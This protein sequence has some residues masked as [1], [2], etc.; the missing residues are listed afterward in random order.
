[1][2][3]VSIVEGPSDPLSKAH[4]DVQ[5]YRRQLFENGVA[6]ERL[7]GREEQIAQRM[8][9]DLADLAQAHADLD[10]TRTALEAALAA[11]V[12]HLATMEGS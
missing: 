6:R 11:A 8:A 2:A 7:A 9:Q 5:G 1:M 10:N 12:A 3:G 4:G